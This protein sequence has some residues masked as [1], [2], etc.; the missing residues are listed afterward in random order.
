MW[1]LQ[2][3]RD[4]DASREVSV[5]SHQSP[6]RYYPLRAC[7]SHSC[8][9]EACHPSAPPCVEEPHPDRPRRVHFGFDVVL[10]VNSALFPAIAFAE[11]PCCCLVAHRS[12]SILAYMRPRARAHVFLP[13]N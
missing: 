4:S 6:M 12:V 13:P 7:S 3:A 11:P 10:H 8:I 2:S 1:L 9:L 5:V